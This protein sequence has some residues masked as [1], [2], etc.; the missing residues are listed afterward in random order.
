MA[1]ILEG[2]VSCKWIDTQQAHYKTIKSL[3]TGKRWT[4]EFIRKYGTLLGTYGTYGNI[5]I[6]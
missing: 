2:G 6:A 3:R 1:L 4:V 5:G